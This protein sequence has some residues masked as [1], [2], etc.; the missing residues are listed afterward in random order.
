MTQVTD[1]FVELTSDSNKS[2]KQAILDGDFFGATGPTG[3]GATG[4]VGPTGSQ[5][6]TG[7][8][9]NTGA[10]GTTGPTGSQ[11]IQG[12]QGVQ[13]IQGEVG[14][15]GSQ[16][17]QG[18][19]GDQGIQGAVGNTGLAGA[20]GN[21]GSTG[22][23]G[24]TGAVGNTGATG[25]VGPTGSIGA[26]GS[27]GITG[28]TGNVG[29]T[30]AAGST[31]PFT[32]DSGAG[33]IQGLVPMPPAGSEAAGDFLSAQGSW[34]YVDQSHPQYPSF[35]LVTQSSDGVGN[36]KFES[37]EIYTGIDGNKRYAVL[38]G[39]GSAATM[40]IYDITNQ[41]TP[42][43]ISSTLLSG[44]YSIDVATISGVVYAFIG[45]SGSNHVYIY[46]ITNPY[47]PIQVANFAITAVTTSIYGVKYVGG[48][49]YCATQN[50]GLVV[51]DVGGGASG[52]TLS[53]PVV[54]YNEEVTLGGSPK[55]FGVTAATISGTTYVF[56]TQFITSVYGTRQIKSWSISTPQTPTLLQSL[57][58]TTVGEVL[59]VSVTGNTAVVMVQASGVYAYDLIDVTSPSAMTNLSQVSAPAGFVTN[60]AFTGVISGNYLF[61]PWGGSSTYGG[62]IQFLDIT[63]RTTP[64]NLAITYTNV[65][66][67]V[68]GGIAVDATN[69]FIFAADYGVSPGSTGTLDVFTMPF[70]SAVAGSVIAST[71]AMKTGAVNGYVFTSDTYGNG[72]WQTP[73]PG[74]TGPTGAV[75]STGP[76]GADSSVAGPT[77]A[78][79]NTGATGAVGNTGSTGIVGPTG[80][81]G[82]TGATGAV[83]NTGSTGSQGPTGAVGNT[84]TTGTVGNTGSTGSTGPTGAVGNT[85]IVGP[86]GAVGNTGATGA[87]GSTG[88]AGVKGSTGNTGVTGAT[89]VGLTGPTGP[90][91]GVTGGTGSTGPTGAVGNTGS[92]GSTG[93]T[94]PTGPTGSTGVGVT[95][96]TGPSGGVTGATGAT[97]PSAV[98]NSEISSSSTITTTSTT[99]VLLTGFTSTPAAG[100]YLVLFSAYTTNASATATTTLGLYVGGVLKADSP[101]GALNKANAVSVVAI[102]AIVTVSGS[103]AI[104]IEWN[105]SASTG[106]CEF[107]TMDFLKIG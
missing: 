85:G 59:G 81:Q 44:S 72:T 34:A 35:S 78:V 71:I 25:I 26:T 92:T 79:G 22:S 40:T 56:T 102:N 58:V 95:G 32:G 105:V 28:L 87:A 11:G 9:G 23:Q 10:V 98:I 62:A 69:G 12:D 33:G 43:L 65:S 99:P 94:G 80:S 97:G 48:Y 41:K 51:L 36:T 19:Q 38:A 70:T 61:L 55:S 24:P 8:V 17:I 74:I 52:G 3:A 45:S 46:N 18:I 50:Q 54:S 53:V 68:F 7:A 83:G 42:V 93:S 77:G 66:S 91:G 88:T 101:R 14:S 84:G 104:A 30:G 39:I 5:G 82:N 2:L 15:T 75:G 4:V 13:G 6:P 107:A 106:S 96:P 103:Q 89:G 49:L 90:S 86:T 47:I 29:P 76:T 63:N 1:E 60:S 67:S 57:Q 73:I 100:T 27:Q 16:G 64:I 21:T 37:V 31:A 20:V